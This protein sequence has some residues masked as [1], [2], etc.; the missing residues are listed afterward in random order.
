MREL[1]Q[2]DE[3]DLFDFVLT[4][5]RG[6]ASIA[7]FIAVFMTVSG[8]YLLILNPEYESEISVSKSMSLP[9][10]YQVDL[11]GD[12]KR[13]FYN[14]SDFKKW[15]QMSPSKDITF[16]VLSDTKSVDGF[17]LQ[18][19]DKER[20]LVLNHKDENRLSALA[21]TN[22]LTTISSYRDYMQFV[23]KSLSEAYRQRATKALA[24][25]LEVQRLG[26]GGVSLLSEKEERLEAFLLALDEGNLMF[27]VS[28][29]SE[30]KKTSPRISSVLI[31][32]I[33]IGG[34]IGV[35][36]VLSR[37]AWQ[38]R[39]QISTNGEGAK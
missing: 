23:N 33:V 2:N 39:L 5:W 1:Q 8:S 19:P 6:K 37:E 20:A 32:A 30:P 3:I 11:F 16:D 7:A 12:F 36:F 35:I 22:D 10:N 28:H 25:I 18:K 21:R 4:L 34:V 9:F 17:E 13:A 14:R 27:E 38:R 26:D 24:S 15:K 29:P 31:F